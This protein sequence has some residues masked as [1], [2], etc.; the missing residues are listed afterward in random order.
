MFAI[1]A[2]ACFDG[3]QFVTGGATVLVDD[4]RIVGIEPARYELPAD[5]PWPRSALVGVT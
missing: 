1:R 3:A 5:C 4:G 2:S